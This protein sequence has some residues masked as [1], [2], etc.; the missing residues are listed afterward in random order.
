MRF[1]GF[2]GPSYT[3]QSVDADCQ[4]CLGMYPEVDETGTGKEGEVAALVGTP[5]LSFL[6]NLQNAPVRGVFTSSAGVLYAVCGNMLYK[7]SSSWVATSLGTLGT[8]VGPVSM[9]DNG[10]NVFIVDGSLQG[11]YVNM[12]SDSFTTVSSGDNF[13]GADQVTFQD[14]YFIFNQIN[15]EQFFLSGINDI[16]F[17]PLDVS[18]AEGSPDNL[19][20][21]ISDVENLYLFGTESL[22]VFYDSGDTFPFV[23]QQGANLP[24]GCA[25]RFTIAK[26]SGGIAWLGQD[27]RGRGIVYKIQGY[28]FQRISTHAIEKVIS[29]LGDLSKARAWVYQYGG[30]EFYCLNIP[31]AESTWCFDAR[32]NLWHE[33]ATLSQGSLSRYRIDCHAFAYNTNVGGDYLNGNLYAID[34]SAYSDNGDPLPRIRTAPHIAKDS[35]R[36]SHHR[37]LLDMETGVGTDGINQ[38]N[39][40]QAMLQWSN[41]RGHTWSNEKWASIGKIGKRLTRVQWNRLGQARDRVYKLVITDPVKVTL[42]GADILVDEEAS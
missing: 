42:L 24:V 29:G 3:L 19:Q 23:R 6:V 31:G 13:P 20:G 9:E 1:R 41:D 32:T 33:R 27:N 37:F 39:D 38:G 14:G 10:A 17:D 25:A 18:T 30:H 36:I 21:L 11:Y 26:F 8:S 22:E 12:T 35:N 5:G 15:S 4:R 40:P 34:P 7:V 2:I 28:Q 16:T